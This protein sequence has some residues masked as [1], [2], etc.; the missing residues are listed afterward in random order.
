MAIRVG[1]DL[2]CADTVT[3]GIEA[4]AERYL[5]RIYT[6]R[7]V[8]DCRSGDRLHPQ[9]LAA[10]FAAKEATWKVLDVGDHPVS[11]L[12]VEVVTDARG[13]MGLSLTGN[14]ARLADNAGISS[15]QL[16]LTHQ[17]TAAAAIVIAETGL[18]CRYARHGREDPP[19]PP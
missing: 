17:R 12:E 11:W 16:S 2:V 15:L 19:R 3:E 5:S 10:R 8:A 13:E 9:R 4:H 14:A 7:E 18:G 6:E 1:L